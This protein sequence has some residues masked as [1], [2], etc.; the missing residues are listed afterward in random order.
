MKTLNPAALAA[1]VLITALSLAAFH[2]Q[3]RQVP[4]NEINGTPVV[5]LAPVTVTA[6]AAEKR[7]ALLGDS[8]VGATV[9]A[10]A[11]ASRHAATASLLSSQFAMPYYS[12]GNKLGRISKE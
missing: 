4:V 11:L 5:N 7:E 3:A 9:A 12:F 1:S 8:V 10:T 6:S 2:S